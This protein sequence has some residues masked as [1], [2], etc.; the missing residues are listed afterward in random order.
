[1]KNN[2]TVSKVKRERNRIVLSLL[3]MEGVIALVDKSRHGSEIG[4][5]SCRKEGKKKNI[6][7]ISIHE[8]E[9]L[10][11]RSNHDMVWLGKFPTFFYHSRKK[12]F[13][14]FFL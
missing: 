4:I 1:M 5:A 11:Y 10:I 6:S 7:K 3:E 13:I 9:S 8:S 2:L 12:L 14:L